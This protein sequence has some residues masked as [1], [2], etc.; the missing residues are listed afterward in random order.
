MEPC[1]L[2]RN[3]A[4][5]WARSRARSVSAPR[6][7]ESSPMR[8]GSIRD[9]SSPLS[10]RM[11]AF[12]ATWL[13]QLSHYNTMQYRKSTTRDDRQNVRYDVRLLNRYGIGWR[14][15]S[16]FHVQ[17]RGNHHEFIASILLTVF[18]QRR[19]HE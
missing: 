2:R 1:R 4:T 13:N 5:F 3:P 12:M 6:C 9:G 11:S 16:T 10:A 17:R 8:S 15:D 18:R 19:Q 7:L 14:C